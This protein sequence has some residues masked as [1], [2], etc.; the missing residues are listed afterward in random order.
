MKA[1]FDSVGKIFIVDEKLLSAVTGLSGSGPAYV[2]VMIE[3]LADGGVRAGGL[4][5]GCFSTF[6]HQHQ[7]TLCNEQARC[8]CCAVHWPA[9]QHAYCTPCGA[10]CSLCCMP[11]HAMPVISPV[12]LL[13]HI[14]QW[15][16]SSAAAA[17]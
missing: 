16:Y 9:E 5:L 13:Q 7:V 8:L 3:A 15:P 14:P 12:Q 10:A 6:W 1:L 17:C 4:V 11:C 2:F